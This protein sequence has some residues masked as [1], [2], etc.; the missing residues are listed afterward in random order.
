MT[1]LVHTAAYLARY[2][3]IG[4]AL[5]LV[6]LLVAR[7]LD[8]GE[9][10]AVQSPRTLDALKT[11]YA[12]AVERA[13]PAVVNI[14]V[15][16]VIEQRSVTILR[17]PQM[18]QF[19]GRAIFGKP[20]YLP[21]SELGS[22]VIVSDDGYILT[23]YHVVAGA[24]AVQV[25]LWDGRITPATVVGQDEETDLAVLR[26]EMAGLPTVP[27]AGNDVL[28]VGDVVLAIGNPF[29]LG[30]TVTMGIVSATGRADLKVST[31]EDF[32]QTDAAINRGNSGGALVNSR[33]EI[34]GISTAMLEHETGAEGIGFAIPID[35][36]LDVMRQIL[37][38][39]RVVRGWLGVEMEDVRLAPRIAASVGDTP[40]VLIS[41]IYPDGPADEA[42]LQPGDYLTHFNGEPV[43]PL[44]D[45]LR[46][47]ADASPGTTV[48]LRF[49]RDGRP[50]EAQSTLIQ[51]PPRL[52]ASG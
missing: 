3:A 36:A 35:L 12:G 7:A 14:Y 21:R 47:I 19:A 42:G 31:Y 32:I 6:A 1:R 39:G 22:G 33:G 27:L 34:I 38:N 5:A 13:S 40:G 41:A 45:L 24:E 28:R 9:D 16:K 17:N 29:G 46:K 25:A 49:L 11:S 43:G 4:L 52:F 30:K 51:R 2:A 48:D 8:N 20:R 44:R 26:V 50:Q 10:T 23:N 15:D 18:Q 37:T